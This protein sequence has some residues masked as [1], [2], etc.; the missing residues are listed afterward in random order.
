MAAMAIHED[1]HWLIET[2]RHFEVAPADD[3]L[4]SVPPALTDAAR[5][6][7]DDLGSTLRSFV[8]LTKAVVFADNAA[9]VSRKALDGERHLPTGFD[10]F[11]YIEGPGHFGRQLQ[12]VSRV[13]NEMTIVRLV[14]N[15]TSYLVEIVGECLRANPK[16]MRSKENA[17]FEAIFS[18]SSLDE[19][20]DTLIN[21]KV[22]EL[23]YLGF[24][25][26]A[27]WID[28]KLGVDTL[29]DFPEKTTLVEFLEVRNCIVHNR[30]KVG[31]K[32]FRVPGRREAFGEVGREIRLKV[33]D[34]LLAS[35]ATSE[36][37]ALLDAAL[38][39]KFSLPQTQTKTARG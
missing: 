2:L 27:V 9:L 3:P 7:F 21:R 22:D 18:C 8:L 20:H 39:S 33:D 6:F 1:N 38:A 30:S 29:S 31:P 5:N 23:A 10:P 35:R 37:V 26:L 12:S 4:F 32:L 11:L 15:F 34:L 28:E 19:L 25:R 14:D 17:T 13:Q 16:I 36:T 24:E